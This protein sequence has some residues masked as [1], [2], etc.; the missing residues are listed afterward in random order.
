LQARVMDDEES[1]I[2]K[3]RPKQGLETGGLISGKERV[4]QAYADSLSGGNGPVAQ[5]DAVDE[6]A[7]LQVQQAFDRMTFSSPAGSPAIFGRNGHFSIVSP[8]SR[9]GDGRK[10]QPVRVIPS[11]WDLTVVNDSGGVKVNCGTIIKN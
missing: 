2:K 10:E 3:A 11:P 9:G 8:R 1:N 7:R 6:I 5:F 4:A